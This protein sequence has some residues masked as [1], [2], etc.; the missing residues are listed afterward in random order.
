MFRTCGR[1]SAHIHLDQEVK[2]S[3]SS[4][5]EDRPRRQ[6][7]EQEQQ[8]STVRHKRDRERHID[9]HLH[10]YGAGEQNELRG[11]TCRCSVA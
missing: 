2:L 8:R 3:C 5:I 10:E 1:T 9:K 11:Q 7:P 6:V 4:A